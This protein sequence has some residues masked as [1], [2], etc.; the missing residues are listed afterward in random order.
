M[1]ISPEVLEKYLFNK[2]VL[3]LLYLESKID[4]KFFKKVL[5]FNEKIRLFFLPIIPKKYR[6]YF[7][8][9]NFYE[10]K[11]KFSKIRVD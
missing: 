3:M 7:L 8:M 2:K 10:I 6:F 4:I 11:R 9:V 1:F 5:N